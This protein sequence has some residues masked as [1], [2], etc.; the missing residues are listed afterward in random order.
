MAQAVGD[1]GAALTATLVNVG[2]Q[3]GLY[4]AMAGSGP[5]TAA[6]LAAETKTTERY[7]AEWLA[8]QAASGYITY[9]GDGR[10]RLPDEQAEALANED[11]PACV[12]GGFQAMT[13]AMRAE[14]RSS[15][16]SA[17]A[18]ASVGTNTILGSLREPSGSSDLATWPTWSARGF[19]L[20][21]G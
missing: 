2:D 12:L 1:L 4:R 5:L 17:R 16:P 20:S 6:E 13:A 15:R 11:S 21:T 10:Y 9:E 18:G 19:P 14:P 7:V 3:L 8:A